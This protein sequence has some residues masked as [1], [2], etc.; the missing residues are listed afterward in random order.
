M[1]SKLT[2]INLDHNGNPLPPGVY[3]VVGPDASLRGYKV[4]WREE[5][6]D[7]VERQRSKSFSVR[8]LRSEAR[9]LS[10][11]V[12]FRQGVEMAVRVD[13]AVQP[14]DAAAAMTVEE[15]FQ[16]W[17]V[18]R[19]AD[20][21]EG[22]GKKVVRYW[23]QEIGTRSIARVRL[24]R[25]S[26]DPAI[27]TRLQD[28]LATEGMTVA[29]RREILKTLRSVLRWGRRRHPNVFTVELS[30]LFEIPRASRHRLAFAADAYALER[31]IE[32]V[33]GRPNRDELLSLRDAAFVAAMGFT[34]AARPSEWLNS[35]TWVDLQQRSVELQRPAD[36]GKENIVGLK[37]GARAA[38]LLPNARERI[39]VYRRALEARYGK[40]PDHGLVFQ[41]LRDDGPIWE[42]TEDG[43]RIPVAWSDD[44]YKHWTARIWRPARDIAANAP[45]APKGLG[46]MT[47]YDC[48]RT[49]ISMALHSTLVIGPHGMNLHMLA[50]WA[51]HDI[52]TLQRY[53]AHFIARYLGKAPIDLEAECKAAKRRVEAEP[54]KPA[55]DPA[56]RQRGAQR[57]RRARESSGAAPARR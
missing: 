43:T 45:G 13:G 17:C 18:K 47:F 27:L 9:A 11:A 35:A 23:D 46:A 10:A 56:G 41:K 25:L 2:E 40:Q 53:Y 7:G 29:K 42:T 34:V 44:D 52:Q 30:G 15:L 26:R 38:L 22:Y 55:K 33:L 4:R 3:G 31:I 49:A 16:E 14:V 20:L 37:T 28:D 50:G 36:V 8:K 51:G 54:F 6:E 1:A 48:R 57:R 19:G 12:E 24:E 39:L 5:G 21:S 32:A